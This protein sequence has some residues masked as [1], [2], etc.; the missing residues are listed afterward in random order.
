M[1]PVRHGGAVQRERTD[2][3]AGTCYSISRL[4]R[5][6]IAAVRALSTATRE[7][8]IWA[9]D[10]RRSSDELAPRVDDGHDDARPAL[11]CRALGGGEHGLAPASS[12]ILRVRR[13]DM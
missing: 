2:A 11:V 13:M 1:P 12:M 5:T 3:T 6:K 8:A 9:P 4:G 10:V 7:L